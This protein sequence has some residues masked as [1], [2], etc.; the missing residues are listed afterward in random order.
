MFETISFETQQKFTSYGL[1]PYLKKFRVYRKK[2]LVADFEYKKV[3]FKFDIEPQRD[4][5]GAVYRK[6]LKIT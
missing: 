5:A 6:S 3:L 1:E 2:C 4:G